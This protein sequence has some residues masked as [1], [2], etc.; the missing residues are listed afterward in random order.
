VSAVVL[1]DSVTFCPAGVSVVGRPG[2]RLLLTANRFVHLL[3][4][5]AARNSGPF[6]QRN[7]PMIKRIR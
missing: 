7:Y 6:F 4:R 2:L 3:W 5:A 1:I